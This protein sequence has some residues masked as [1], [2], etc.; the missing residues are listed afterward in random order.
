M[1]LAAAPPPKPPPAYAF[2][3]GSLSLAG[4]TSSFRQRIGFDYMR[5][6]VA[7][8][9]FVRL[10][11]WVLH[12]VTQPNPALRR[13]EWVDGRACPS[14]D[15]AMRA[16]AAQPAPRFSDPSDAEGQRLTRRSADGTDFVLEGQGALPLDATPILPFARHRFGCKSRATTRGRSPPGSRSWISP[17]GPAGRARRRPLTGAHGHGL[18][19]SRRPGRRNAGRDQTMGARAGRSDVSGPDAQAQPARGRVRPNCR[20]GPSGEACPGCGDNSRA[21]ALSRSGSGRPGGPGPA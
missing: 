10:H 19:R 8:P 15:A 6:D 1:P 14:L 13:E 20:A 12:R 17:P 21:A 3:W 2:A 11:W 9:P 4:E 5:R 18:R 16:L 7:G